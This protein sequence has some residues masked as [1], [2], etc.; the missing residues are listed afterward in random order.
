[1][2][3]DWKPHGQTVVAMESRNGV[4]VVGY[5]DGSVVIAQGDPKS[6]LVAPAE[7]RRIAHGGALQFMETAE[8]I[9]VTAG[10]DGDAKIWNLDDGKSLFQ[11]SG[12]PRLLAPLDSLTRQT[13]IATRVKAH[14]DKKVPE[15]EKLW[16]A[17]SEKAKKAGEA[18]ATARRD[19][20]GKEAAMQKLES[21]FPAPKEEEIAKAREA[22]TAS[23]RALTGAIRNRDSAARLGGDAF[24]R[25]T[26][27]LSAALEAETLVIALKK[28]EEALK[29][30]IEEAKAK[31][32]RTSLSLSTDGALLIESLPDGGL[33]LWSTRSGQW[34]E[35]LPSTPKSSLASHVQ[36]GAL[37]LTTQDKK[38]QLVE[39]PGTS[40]TLEKTLGDGIEAT[41]FVDRVSAL[42][43]SP[44][45]RHLLTGTGVPSRDGEIALWDT[46]NW[47][48]VR[49]ND[50]AHH[51]TITAF[52]FSPDGTQFASGGTDQM[53]R[54]FDIASL[55]EV[56][57]F[58][59]H[60]SHVLDVAWNPDNLTLASSGADLEAK[61]WDFEETR[62]KSKVEGFGKE[63]SAVAFL[64]ASGSLVTASGDKTLKVANQPLPG[65]GVTF[66]H[67][68]EVS[69][70]GKTIIAGGQDGVLRVW[71]SAAKKLTHSFAPKPKNSEVASKE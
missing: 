46:Q 21:A 51:D 52:A 50:Q 25:H 45:G 47:D 38:A 23:K 49:V 27:A 57:V 40:W 64:G 1:M 24:A 10:P 13:T 3:I 62:Q 61:I 37:L 66:L 28:E 31:T 9:L 54:V 59:G 30:S 60:T 39:L 22:V 34:L 67:T 56:K 11:L 58:E 5:E 16:K 35:D 65:A 71:D 17:E 8:E 26:E 4:L 48:R 63:V 15:E 18:I 7:T 44:D 55:E 68:A 20:A 36:K 33:R 69:G 12:D 53:V 42:S 6:P 32:A 2:W 41:P 43:F 70:D 19:L 29:K 14:W